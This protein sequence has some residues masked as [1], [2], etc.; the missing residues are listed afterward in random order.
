[1]N[2][3]Q[4]ADL[5]NIVRESFLFWKWFKEIRKLWRDILQFPKRRYIHLPSKAVEKSASAPLHIHN[6]I[7]FTSF[8][9]NKIARSRKFR[10]YFVLPFCLWN[11]GAVVIYKIM[12]EAAIHKHSKT[13]SGE[14]QNISASQ[15][16]NA[17]A[18]DRAPVAE[19]E[20]CPRWS[21]KQV[22]LVLELGG[23]T[24]KI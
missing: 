12:I 10:V 1:M 6:N 15:Y 19:M 13:N 23:F 8:L 18:V 2:R 17:H 16:I 20:S 24:A 3:S 5:E 9:S 21:L 4:G 11:S 7:K 22:T 14:I